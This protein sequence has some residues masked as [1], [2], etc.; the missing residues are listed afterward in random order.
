MERS[1]AA[2]YL[3]Q[4]AFLKFHRRL[5]MPLRLVSGDKR[6]SQMLTVRKVLEH[7]TGGWLGS[8]VDCWDPAAIRWIVTLPPCWLKSGSLFGVVYE[9]VIIPRRPVLECGS[10]QKAVC[11]CLRQFWR[12][13]NTQRMPHGC[14]SEMLSRPYLACKK[15]AKRSCYGETVGLVYIDMSFF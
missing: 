3:G 9:V 4:S 8:T 1:V 2:V 15:Y 6:A 7:S 5:L 12:R 11:R 10:S 13:H 14:A